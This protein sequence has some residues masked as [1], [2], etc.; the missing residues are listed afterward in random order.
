MDKGPILFYKYVGVD[1]VFGDYNVD[2][3]YR[4]S[5]YKREI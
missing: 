5:S 3:T 1:N 2:D 4:L